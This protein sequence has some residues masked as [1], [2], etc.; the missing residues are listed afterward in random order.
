MRSSEPDLD[1]RIPVLQTGVFATSPPEHFAEAEGFEPSRRLPACVLSRDVPS[2]SRPYFHC[3]AEVEGFE[4][5]RRYSRPIGFQDRPHQPARVH[6]RVFFCKGIPSITFAEI[7][8]TLAGFIAGIERIEL[9]TNGLTVRC[10]TA[11][12]YP[13]VGRK[14][15]LEPLTSGATFRRSSC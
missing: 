1:R 9:T 5:S 6:F 12:L 2:A 13:H 8:A 7:P 3:P 10:S 15:G 11:E 4:P 14:K